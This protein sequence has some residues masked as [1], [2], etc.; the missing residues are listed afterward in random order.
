[1]PIN[2][3]GCRI[4]GLLFNKVESGNRRQIRTIESNRRR[5]P[6][7]AGLERICRNNQLALELVIDNVRF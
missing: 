2:T 3:L 4:G 6:D 5:M 7:W 1:M